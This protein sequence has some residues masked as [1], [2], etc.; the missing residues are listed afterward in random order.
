MIAVYDACVLYPAPVRDILLEFAVADLVQAKWTDQIHQEWVGNLVKK[1]PEI[2]NSILRTKSLMDEAGPD[3]I[4]RNYESLID[5]ITLPDSKDCHVLA[6]AVK[7]GAQY[8]VTK[9]LKDFPKNHL[10]PF[11][12]EA[13]HPDKFIEHHYF[14]NQSA[15]ISCVKQIRVRLQNPEMNAADY[16]DNLAKLGLPIT[17]QLLRDYIELI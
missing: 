12:V 14:L 5:S 13:I 2:E 6:A 3:A 15:V 9:N 17:E 4:V 11:D 16:L 7:C 8:I 10:S 1:R